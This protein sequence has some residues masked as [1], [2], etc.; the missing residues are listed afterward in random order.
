MCECRTFAPK[1]F[2]LP[3]PTYPREWL[4]GRFASPQPPPVPCISVSLHVDMYNCNTDTSL[5]SLQHYV[6]FFSAKLLS[7][8]TTYS[9]RRSPSPRGVYYSK[10]TCSPSTALNVPWHAEPSVW[11]SSACTAPDKHDIMKACKW[12]NIARKWVVRKR[13]SKSLSNDTKKKKRPSDMESVW[14]SASFII[15]AL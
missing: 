12:Q 5:L 2:G 9:N 3:K 1:K 6:N 4:S 13:V 7:K 14:D 10:R 8:P 15:P 11:M